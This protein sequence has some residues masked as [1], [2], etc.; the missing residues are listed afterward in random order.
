MPVTEKIEA[1]VNDFNFDGGG[2]LFWIGIRPMKDRARYGFKYL[3][4][5]GTVNDSTSA[6]PNHLGRDRESMSHWPGYYETR[7]EALETLKQY[8]Y[9]L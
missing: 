5:D 4:D 9:T 2:S 7:D 3:W 6:G 1:E 8:G